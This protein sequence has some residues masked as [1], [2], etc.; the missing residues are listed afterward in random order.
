MFHSLRIE[1]VLLLEYTGAV[2]KKTVL[3]VF[4]SLDVIGVLV[5][6]VPLIN[7]GNGF[8]PSPFLLWILP[9]VGFYGASFQV[10]SSLKKQILFEARQR[11]RDLEVFQKLTDILPSGGSISLLRGH[12]FGGPFDLDQLED[13][14]EFINTCRNPEF[15]FIDEELESL[16]QDLLHYVG[17]FRQI[18][19]RE[20]FPISTPNPDRHLNRIPIEMIQQ[21]PERYHAIE[22]ELNDLADKIVKTYDNLIRRGRRKL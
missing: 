9:I 12:D 15:E 20:T 13:L 6:Y 11:E 5:N 4:V 19:G 17:A 18:I 8:K 16:K 3:W 7:K 14:T 2:L 10:Y 22:N 21:N 1:L